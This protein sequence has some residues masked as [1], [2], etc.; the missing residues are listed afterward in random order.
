MG[1]LATPPSI[2]DQ[3]KRS[4]LE[5]MREIVVGSPMTPPS[6]GGIRFSVVGIKV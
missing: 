2:E 6:V 4:L 3:T 5:E 1:N